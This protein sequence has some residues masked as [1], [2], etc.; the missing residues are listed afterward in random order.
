MKIHVCLEAIENR[1]YSTREWS[2]IIQPIYRM[3]EARKDLLLA[4]TIWYFKFHKAQFYWELVLSPHNIL[5]G[6]STRGHSA[7]RGQIKAGTVLQ[8]V[9]NFIN[10]FI[11]GRQP[12]ATGWLA[13]VGCRPASDP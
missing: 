4:E 8:P 6:D 10:S 5:F 12:T 3:W 9:Y 7:V 1:Q 11:L 2:Y 13:T